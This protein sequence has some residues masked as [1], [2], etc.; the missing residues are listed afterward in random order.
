MPFTACRTGC[1]IFCGHPNG[2]G[3][4]VSSKH[5]SDRER[6]P[7]ATSL[8]KEDWWILPSVAQPQ[9]G[10]RVSSL[11]GDFILWRSDMPHT[12]YAPS[13]PAVGNFHRLGLF[14]SAAVVHSN[15]DVNAAAKKVKLMQYN[16]GCTTSHNPIYP[17][18]QAGPNSMSNPKSG[19][20]HYECLPVFPLL[21]K[22]HELL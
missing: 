7:R 19:A 1:A 16:K 18:T 2:T 13:G 17:K 12:N 9:H 14:V 22:L 20:R 5:S 10:I 15:P 11:T 3:L 4:A 6:A 21:S 8:T